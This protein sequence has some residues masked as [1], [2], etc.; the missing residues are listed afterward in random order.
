MIRWE[1]YTTADYDDDVLL[2]QV[3]ADTFSLACA[4]AE[5]AFPERASIVRPVARVIRL[6]EVTTLPGTHPDAEQP[7]RLNVWQRLRHWEV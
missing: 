7:D 6:S 4:E 5:R 1:V 3:T 2:G